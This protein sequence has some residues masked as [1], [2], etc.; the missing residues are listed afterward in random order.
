MAKPATP[1]TPTPAEHAVKQTA[2]A[3]EHQSRKVAD[4]AQEIKQSSAQIEDSAERTTR[5]AA[6]R[7]LLA[8]ERT[9]A[10]WVRTGLFALAS[11]VGAR[12]LLTGILPQWVTQL[13]ASVLVAFSVFCF[14]A[15]IWRQR[16]L[17]PSAYPPDVKRIPPGL[18]IAVNTF[19]A[20]VS[21][22]V[23]IGIWFPPN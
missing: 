19:L 18:L 6:D 12:T 1:A 15:A 4:S 21:F 8:A 9:Y 17:T 22:A 23:L 5:L 16:S 20:L 2:K 14:A 11:G 3:V 13:D 10:A 7:T